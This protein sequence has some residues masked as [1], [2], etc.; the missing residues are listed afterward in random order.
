MSNKKNRATKKT[1]SQANSKA[2]KNAPATAKA[3][4]KSKVES[5]AVEPTKEAHNSAKDGISEE[6]IAKIIGTIVAAIMVITI[7][8]LAGYYFFKNQHNVDKGANLG[9]YTSKIAQVDVKPEGVSDTYGFNISKNGYNKPV[10]GVPTVGIYMDFMCPGCGN[11]EQLNG[12]NLKKM[13]EAGQINVEYHF[14]NFLDKASPDKYSARTASAAA[15][16]AQKSPEHLL[17][18]VSKMMSS[19]IQP[20]ENSDSTPSDDDIVKY[21]K[22]VG[23]PE[24]VAK[25]AVKAGYADWISAVNAYTIKRPSLYNLSGDYAGKSMSTPAITVNGRLIDMV[26]AGDKGIADDAALLQSLGIAKNKVGDKD[27]KIGLGATGEPIP[28]K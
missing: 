13:V 25:E 21:A 18:F 10:K 16:I 7:V 14:M 24:N 27:Y 23:V 5:K 4:T 20:E 17:E 1:S 28:F 11:F 2:M 22:G 26:K 6:T 9:E 3:N 12:S 19:G 8:A 15:Y